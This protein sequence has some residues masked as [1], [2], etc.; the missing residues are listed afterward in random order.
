MYNLYLSSVTLGPKLLS[1]DK[2]L[3][4][5]LV[6]YLFS[7]FSPDRIMKSKHFVTLDVKKERVTSLKVRHDESSTP[8]TTVPSPQQSVDWIVVFTFTDLLRYIEKTNK[9]DNQFP[10]N[11]LF[12]ISRR[13]LKLLVTSSVVLSIVYS[14]VLS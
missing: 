6:F 7:S 14:K 3:R 12:L 10:N 9:V 2:T 4:R 1:W 13:F 11:F 5:S 8:K